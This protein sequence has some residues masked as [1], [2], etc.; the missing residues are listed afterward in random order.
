MGPRLAS[1]G[2][3][4]R[5]SSMIHEHSLQ[6]D[7]GS[8]AAE[9]TPRRSRQPLCGTFNGTAA[10]EP[11]KPVSLRR[12]FPVCAAFNGTAAREPRK[13]G[14]IRKA[15]VRP[16]PSMGPRLASRGSVVR[17]DHAADD[18]TL[19]W[20]RGSRAAEARHVAT[21]HSQHRALQWDRGSRAAEACCA[22][23]A[24]TGFI[25]FNGTAA[26]EP[27]K[28]EHRRRRRQPHGPSMGPR[29]ASRGSEVV[30]LDDVV[31]VALQWDRGSRAAEAR[32]RYRRFL[33]GNP[34][35]GPRLASRGS[36]GGAD[37]LDLPLG[38]SMGPRLASRGSV[39]G[40]DID[41]LPTFPSMGPRLASRG[42]S[43]DARPM[44]RLDQPSMGPRLASRG[45][46][47]K[48][49]LSDVWTFLQWDRGSRAAEA[50]PARRNSLRPGIPFNGT[51]AREPR[52]L[53]P[54]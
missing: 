49:D 28:P 20:D 14:Q 13:R 36:G 39:T 7:R 15:A 6:W 19:Q 1:R 9:A 44:M 10:R 40:S 48:N 43:S 5:R 4:L 29:L 21:R 41:S 11:R 51:A 25:A 31:I 33:L 8:R 53:P 3:G 12:A 52:K 32:R 24:T 2:S 27:R 54:P 50:C 23:L 34:S 16:T 37:L 26:R 42:S 47:A 17:S 22:S 18:F 30:S 35:M 46:Q 38:P 45:S